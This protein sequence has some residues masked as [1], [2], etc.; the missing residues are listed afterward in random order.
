MHSSG[1]ISAFTCCTTI[2]VIISNTFP[3]SQ[4]ESGLALPTNS[5]L[6]VLP[7]TICEGR[8]SQRNRAG[9]GFCLQP[10]HQSDR[11]SRAPLSLSGTHCSLCTLPLSTCPTWSCLAASAFATWRS[12]VGC[13]HPSPAATETGCFVGSSGAQEDNSC[14]P[15]HARS[16]K[17]CF[18]CPG[19]SL[20][21]VAVPFSMC[22]SSNLRLQCLWN[23]T[24]LV[25]AS[26]QPAPSLLSP[27]SIRG[28]AA[29][30]AHSP[31]TGSTRVAP[32]SPTISMNIQSA[33]STPGVL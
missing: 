4:S 19:L 33:D 5:P 18:G 22:P 15:V 24:G 30:L 12:E 21:I 27:I 26:P 17:K 2:V 11:S 6:P 32:I 29:S 7:P 20:Q 10:A 16:L 23:P 9:R 13:R 8:C 14:S 28:Q 1:A 31:M 25:N 3:S